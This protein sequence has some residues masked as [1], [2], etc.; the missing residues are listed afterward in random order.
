MGY[1]SFELNEG[2]WSVRGISCLGTESGGA[3][4]AES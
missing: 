2:D 4:I 1:S 3:S